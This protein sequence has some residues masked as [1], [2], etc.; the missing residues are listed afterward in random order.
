MRCQLLHLHII[1][2]IAVYKRITCRE[3]QILFVNF[4]A[5]P[6]MAASLYNSVNVSESTRQLEFYGI[7]M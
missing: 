4:S 3:S 6:F 5:S 7:H 2:Q 1:I